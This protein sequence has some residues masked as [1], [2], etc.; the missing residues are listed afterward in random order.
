MTPIRPKEIKMSS[1]VILLGL[2]TL[3]IL[4]YVLKLETDAEVEEMYT[5]QL[6]PDTTAISSEVTSNLETRILG[7]DDIELIDLSSPVDSAMMAKLSAIIKASGDRETPREEELLAFYQKNKRSYGGKIR[8]Q[9]PFY[10]FS[11]I[12]L[13]GQ[14]LDKSRSALASLNAG[15]IDLDVE[16]F[17][18]KGVF[19]GT[20]EWSN[21]KDSEIYSMF[22]SGFGNKIMH[23]IDSSDGGTLPCWEGP[24][25]GR[26][27]YYLV[28]IEEAKISQPPPLEQVRQEVLNDWRLSKISSH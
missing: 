28:C 4:V 13:G 2:I 10:F 18:E 22:G 17:S 11:S 6:I 16:K 5:K 3:V 15:L 12:Q 27:G 1:S 7:D 21:E 9:F 20:Y 23:I 8:L 19:D 25:S 14:A 26:L 24:I